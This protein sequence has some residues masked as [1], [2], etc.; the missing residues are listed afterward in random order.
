MVLESYFSA[1]TA[2]LALGLVAYSLV[3]RPRSAVPFALVGLSVFLWESG[4]AVVGQATTEAEAWA[5]Y[6]WGAWGFC[7][8]GWA[9]M[10]FLFQEAGWTWRRTLAWST[11]A[12]A[13]GMVFALQSSFGVLYV[14]GF[15]LRAGHG[16]G[17]R[18]ATSSPWFWA[19]NLTYL[20]HLISVV[21]LVVVSVR[22]PLR[23]V[24]WRGLLLVG[25]Y[26]VTVLL[27][28]VQSSWGPMSG[29]V[30]VVNPVV[31]VNAILL[32]GIFAVL[33]KTEPR[34]LEAPWIEGKV[35]DAVHDGIAVFDLS[36]R[37]VRAN[38][39]WTA[40][41]PEPGQWEPRPLTDGTGEP[42]GTLGQVRRQGAIDSVAHRYGLSLREER[43]AVQV[44]GGLTNKEIAQ[45]LDLSEASVKAILTQIFAKTGARD[46]EELFRWL[47]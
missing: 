22:Q 28:V 2:Y 14:E 11:P 20:V 44:L 39:A 30:R 32:V 26:L 23:R 5:G 17:Y 42:V 38:P 37:L 24:R 46:R 7:F 9:T 4:F 31:P 16:T 18:I 40:L 8:T 21:V 27:H 12:L 33:W 6:R 10:V 25:L 36:G 35:L 34:L 3:A 29:S 15:D 47:V 1:L 41:A 19:F 13:A 45:A 43:V